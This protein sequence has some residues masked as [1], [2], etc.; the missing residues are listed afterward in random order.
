VRA[1]TACPAY[2]SAPHWRRCAGPYNA[3]TATRIEVDLGIEELDGPDT[4]G[5]RRWRGPLRRAEPDFYVFSP[6]WAAAAREEPCQAGC[7][8]DDEYVPLARFVDAFGH[9]PINMSGLG[10]DDVEFSGRPRSSYSQDPPPHIG[11]RC[12]A[13]LQLAP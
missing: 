4:R 12:G 8:L 7:P 11:R 9:S 13:I 1:S 3:R 2:P 6:Q 10:A 5:T